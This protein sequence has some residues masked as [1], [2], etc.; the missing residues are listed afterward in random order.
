MEI[1]LGDE[2]RARNVALTDL[3]RRRLLD[4]DTGTTT[5][6]P[7]TEPAQKKPRLGR[8]GKPWRGRKRRNSED[9]ARDKLVEQI[10]HESRRTSPAPPSP[11]A[12]DH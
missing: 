2:A 7:E 5:T 10:L 11:A 3:A 1:D 8:D 4:A 12:V 6:P 9:I